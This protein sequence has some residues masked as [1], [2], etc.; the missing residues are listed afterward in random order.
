M[1]HLPRELRE[2]SARHHGRE[3]PWT[4]EAELCRD[5]LA[6]DEWYG[7]GLEPGHIG[8]FLIAGNLDVYFNAY[9]LEPWWCLGNLAAEPLGRI[10]RRFEEDDTPALKAITRIPAQ[11]LVREFADFRGRKVYSSADDLARLCLLRFLAKR[12]GGPNQGGSPA[13]RHGR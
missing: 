2:S 8:W 13:H 12:N 11:R 3:M 1:S 9:G 7:Y 4:P 5:I 10:L 6:R